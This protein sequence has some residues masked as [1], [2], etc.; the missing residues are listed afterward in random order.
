MIS[1]PH[2][3]P[4]THTHPQNTKACTDHFIHQPMFAEHPVCQALSWA[5]RP[6]AGY[7]ADKPFLDPTFLWGDK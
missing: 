4:E 1:L 2:L 7:E 3:Y 6:T 5:L